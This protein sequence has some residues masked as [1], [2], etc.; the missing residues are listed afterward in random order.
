MRTIPVSD[1]TYAAIWSKWQEG[2]S[3]EDSILRRILGLSK[4]A[5]S[6]RAVTG[7]DAAGYLDERY[8]VS[9]RRGFEIFRTFKGQ[10]RRA[11]A[12]NGGWKA[13]DGAFLSSLNQL[14]AHIGAPT[15]NAWVGWNYMDDGRVRPIADLRDPTKVRRRIKWS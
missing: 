3:G 5:T 6:P 13:E 12:Q 11:I 15:E 1:G 8:G 14:S 9:F 10:H 4:V 2:D 7:D